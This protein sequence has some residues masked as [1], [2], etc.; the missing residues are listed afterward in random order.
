MNAETEQIPFQ[1]LQTECKY[2]LILMIS[3]FNTKKKFSLPET[4]SSA[5]FAQLT[6]IK[7]SHSPQHS[8]GR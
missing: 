8:R 1:E 4:T 5:A 3:K 7:T 2:R 6:A